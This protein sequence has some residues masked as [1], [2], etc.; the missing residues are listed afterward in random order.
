MI[1]LGSSFAFMP[2]FFAMHV[3][4]AQPRQVELVVLATRRS[5][6][7]IAPPCIQHHPSPIT[8]P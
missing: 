4:D 3:F 5:R 8:V 2:I 1:P 7:L 6:A